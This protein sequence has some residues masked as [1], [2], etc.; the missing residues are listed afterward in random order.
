MRITDL[1]ASTA[2][3][4]AMPELAIRPHA[5][6]FFCA[7]LDAGGPATYLRLNVIPDGGMSRV[8]VWGTRDA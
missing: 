1:I 6:N 2:W 4:P 5:R 8:R 7:Q 3:R